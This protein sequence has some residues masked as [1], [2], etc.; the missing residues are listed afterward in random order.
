M[1]SEAY[2]RIK[3]EKTAHGGGDCTFTRDGNNPDDPYT[4]S[5][6]NVDFDTEKFDDPYTVSVKNVDF[7]TEKFPT[8]TWGGKDLS[9]GPFIYT[10]HRLQ[11]FVPFRTIDAEDGTPGNDVGAINL[12]NRFAGFDPDGIPD[13]NGR[14]TVTASNPG[15]APTTPVPVRRFQVTATSRTT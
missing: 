8:K 12:S 15:T 7:D 14:T 2:M 11:F 13:A 5:V 9:A 1:G 6:K 3:P 10:S 4:V